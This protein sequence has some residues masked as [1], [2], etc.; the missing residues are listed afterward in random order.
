RPIRAGTFA[1]VRAAPAVAGPPP[2]PPPVAPVVPDTEIEEV[3]VYASRS[4]VYPQPGAG[5]AE[6]TRDDIE[7]LPGL[8]QDV[9]R[10]TEYLPGTATNGVS[11]R[12][13]VRGGRQNELA[14]YYAGTPLFEPFHFK[15]FQGLLGV[16]DP[17]VVGS[18]DFY[19]GVLPARFGDRLSGALDIVPRAASN[20]DTWVFGL[21]P[22]YAS[23]V[24][25]GK[26]DSR[27]I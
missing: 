25:T 17:A 20:D 10:V 4:R 21:S 22:L 7:A 14:V 11:S 18:L 9:L 15:D 1:I 23:A 8:D 16:L 26:L 19:S 2:A 24:T 13:Y 5:A 12:P 6:L 27:R 3:A